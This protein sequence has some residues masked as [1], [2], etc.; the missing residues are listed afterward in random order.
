PGGRPGRRRR[1]GARRDARGLRY[2]GAGRV[3]GTHEAAAG[4]AVRAAARRRPLVRHAP[5]RGGAGAAVREAAA[6]AARLARREGVV[7]PTCAGGRGEGA[8]GGARGE[9]G[10]RGAVAR[11]RPSAGV[12]RPGL[13]GGG[14]GTGL[15]E[16]RGD[17]PCQKP[18]SPPRELRHDPRCTLPASTRLPT[19]GRVFGS[20]EA[21]P[22]L[23][24]LGQ[25][26]P[27]ARPAEGSGG[28]RWYV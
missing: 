22:V 9:S 7:V 16:A 12:A 13:T 3:R 21:W 19:A 10:G 15:P 8:R 26:E 5:R 2:G 11:A 14:A 28:T 17:G 24:R 25:V 20:D 27:V 1:R 6:A 23:G 4:D 18:V